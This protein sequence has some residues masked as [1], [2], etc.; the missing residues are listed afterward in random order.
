[1]KLSK[2]LLGLRRVLLGGI[3]LLMVVANFEAVAA[4]AGIAAWSLL[5]LLVLTYLFDIAY[6]GIGNPQLL[7]RATILLKLFWK[8]LNAPPHRNLNNVKGYYAQEQYDWITDVKF[9]EKI[10]H[11]RRKAAMLSKAPAYIGN[12]EVLDLGCGTGLITQTLPG[13]V[14]GVDISPWKVERARRHCPRATFIV[15]DIEELGTLDVS[16][17]FDA[18]VC[19]DVLEHL[20]RPDKAVAAAWRALKSGGVLLGTVPTRSIVWKLRRFLTTADSS[21]EPFHVYYSREMIRKLLV[22]Y[23]ICEISRQCLGLEWFFAATKGA[24]HE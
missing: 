14:L 20:E 23:N 9:P 11:D 4:G 15:D 12:S 5:I 22:S 10:L 2:E 7:S 6:H 17:H 21:G 24:K 16:D 13:S 1:M 8:G 18:V 3:L 19:T